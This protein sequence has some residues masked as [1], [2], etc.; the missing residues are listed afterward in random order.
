MWGV[1]LTPLFYM[2][3]EYFNINSEFR[4]CELKI[5]RK[6]QKGRDDYSRHDIRM[7]SDKKILRYNQQ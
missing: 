3:H 4:D 1:S 2:R 6:T 7:Q 5:I